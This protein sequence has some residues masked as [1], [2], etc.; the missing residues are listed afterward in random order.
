MFL[1]IVAIPRAASKI[2]S[3][4]LLAVHWALED[5]HAYCRGTESHALA[6]RV[7][8]SIVS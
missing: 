4:R 6:E 8:F 5:T 7:G 3:W 1:H 2:A